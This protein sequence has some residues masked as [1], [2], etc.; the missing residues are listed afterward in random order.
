MSDPEEYTEE[1]PKE[2]PVRVVELLVPTEG[3]GSVL[4]AS[5]GQKLLGDGP[6]PEGPCKLVFHNMLPAPP[7]ATLAA[8]LDH[9]LLLTFA[10]PLDAENHPDTILVPWSQI[11]YLTY[12]RRRL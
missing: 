1:K 6:L 9:G 3:E 10:E 8:V 7:R 12:A 11:A 2:W 5:L 4:M